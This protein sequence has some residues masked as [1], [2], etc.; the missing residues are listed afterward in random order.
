MHQFE[1]K[2]LKLENN[3]V[4]QNKSLDAIN[5]TLRS[6]SEILNSIKDILRKFSGVSEEQ[7][8]QKVIL[9]G[10]VHD[11]RE[12]KS[13]MKESN[14]KAHDVEIKTLKSNVDQNRNADENQNKKAFTL[15]ISILSVF[16]TAILSGLVIYFTR[17]K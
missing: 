15:T 6:N 7:T 17:L 2:L 12:F 16:F 3:A 9:K 5:I 8:K 14:C 4:Y 13:F 11:S 1:E 10:L